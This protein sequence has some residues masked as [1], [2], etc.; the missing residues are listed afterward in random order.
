[1]TVRSI[2]LA[3][4]LMTA[5]LAPGQRKTPAHF[6]VITVKPHKASA[7][8]MSGWRWTSDGIEMTN[9]S[10]R[11][12]VSASAKV[13]PWLVFGLPP[14]GE[15]AKW[16]ISAKVT[17]AEMK[18]I[19]KVTPDERAVL[20]GSLLTDRF[21]LVSHQETKVQPVFLMTV[22]PAGLKIKQSPP[23]PPGEPEPKFGRGSMMINNGKLEARYIT[24]ASVA[25]SLT[26]Q[27]E[28]TVLDKTGATEHYDFDLKWQPENNSGNDNG[29]AEMDTASSIFVALK[30]QLGL[31]LTADKA[32]V[33]TVVVD[34]IVQ[35]EAD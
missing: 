13:Q 15:S 8:N 2:A 23:L 30:E 3:F 27:A 10:A 12:M 35:P 1:M 7:S 4:A 14:W 28:R 29:A 34:K 11:T 25:E 33:P 21:G 32:P 16:D 26:R 22:M 6:D 17:D 31:K 20:I 5:T 9:V 19:E 24:M 18:P